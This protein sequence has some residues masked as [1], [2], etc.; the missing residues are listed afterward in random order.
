MRLTRR[1]KWLVLANAVT[2]FGLYSLLVYAVPLDGYWWYFVSGVSA[3]TVSSGFF[4]RWSQK[5][6]TSE[7]TKSRWARGNGYPTGK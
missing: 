2:I 3:A 5:Q 4:A 7:P 1:A 6:L